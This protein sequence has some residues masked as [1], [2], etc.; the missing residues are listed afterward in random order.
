MI[1]KILHTVFIFSFSCCVVQ[2]KSLKEESTICIS[3][4]K[5]ACFGNCPVYNILILSNET[6]IYN[7][8]QFVDSI[9]KYSFNTTKSTISKIVK[10]ARYINF[11]KIDENEYFN[12]YIQD[13]PSTI[14]TIN[15]HKVRYNQNSNEE[16]VELAD[17][18]HKLSMQDCF[19]KK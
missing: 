4:Q 2:T 7:G 9:G 19:I 1:R 6:G 8:K 17:Y 14:I 3:L 5:T 18:I 11:F 16:L 12:A 13:L 10:K 15:N